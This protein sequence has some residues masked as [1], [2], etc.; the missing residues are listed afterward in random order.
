MAKSLIKLIKENK[1][2]L[3]MY[4]KSKIEKILTKYGKFN[5]TKLIK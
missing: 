1:K 5:K 2:T 4:A 3:I